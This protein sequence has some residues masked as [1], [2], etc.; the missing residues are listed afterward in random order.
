YAS[1]RIANLQKGCCL[2][3]ANTRLSIRSQAQLCAR[4]YC[5]LIVAIDGA[6]IAL[7]TVIGAAISQ[8]GP[9]VKAFL[10]HR[11]SVSD[12][13]RE[14]IEQMYRLA[15]QLQDEAIQKT[16]ELSIMRSRGE[17]TDGYSIAL[18]SLTELRIIARLYY[19]DILKNDFDRLYQAYSE[20]Q[21]CAGN[22]ML[23]I[24]LGFPDMAAKGADGIGA[25]TESLNGKATEFQEALA[26]LCKR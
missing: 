6:G 26:P 16:Q 21:D 3:R 4:Q 18:D 7:G 15:E 10:E 19:A 9:M 22:L 12:R 5:E 2:F 23:G 13:D 24:G 25:A 14:R 20:W 1:V 11:D 17:V 8:I